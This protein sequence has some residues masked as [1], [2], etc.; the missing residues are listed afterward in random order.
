MQR[1]FAHPPAADRATPRP[2]AVAGC[3]LAATLSLLAVVAVATGAAV[4]TAGGAQAASDAGH[5]P[6][7]SAHAPVEGPR[8]DPVPG[9]AERSPAAGQR[10]AAVTTDETARVRQPADDY[11]LRF[12][13]AVKVPERTVTL[14]GT[15]YT[16]SRIAR[17]PPNASGLSVAVTSP[18]DEIYRVYLYD[19]DRRIVASAR[20]QGTGD[21]RLDVG[22]LGPGT[23]LAVVQH[24]GVTQVVR[25]V[26]LQGY[27]LRAAAPATA[28]TGQ[29]VRVVASV[30]PG[31]AAG[32]DAAVVLG[33]ATATR[34][35]NATRVDGR[36]VATVDT[37][38]LDAGTY[39]AYA[40]V[41]G[42]ETA[43]G[44][45][46]VLAVA[47][48]GAVSLR[49]EG[50]GTG[51]SSPVGPATPARTP[52]PGGDRDPTA[53]ADADTDDGDGRGDADDG[54]GDDDGS[55]SVITPATT[56]RPPSTGA[57]EGSDAW[58]DGVS[59]PATAAV[60][61]LAVALLVAWRA[62]GRDAE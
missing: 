5:A 54:D 29:P 49:A 3:L 39:R 23:Y 15:D 26:V 7:G 42:T 43:R 14:E 62:R 11:R 41:Q 59:G 10:P 19:A 12:A 13:D 27:D 21:A 20:G 16:V 40:L 45:R 50:N 8:T 37:A 33:D 31:L 18:P 36:L 6:V 60:I 9:V 56:R 1:P 55:A 51:D 52:G 28:A 25:P 58:L 22:G 46:E 24:R 44:R 2:A 47:G 35:A 48:A 57:G 30:T 38:S 32:H 61:A 53:D 17:A 34:R 4:P